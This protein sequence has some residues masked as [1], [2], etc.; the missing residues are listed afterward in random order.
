MQATTKVTNDT[1]SKHWPV[2]AD[3]LIHYSTPED[4]FSL[5]DPEKGSWFIQKLVS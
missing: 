1:K 3:I 4:I 5:R 2:D